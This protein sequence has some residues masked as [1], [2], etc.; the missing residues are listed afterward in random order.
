MKAQMSSSPCTIPAVGKV[1]THP[2]IIELKERMGHEI[3]SRLVRDAIDRMRIKDTA[4]NMDLDAICDKIADEAERLTEPSLRRVINATG[5]VIHTNLGRAPMSEAAANR[6]ARISRGYTNLEIDRVTGRRGNRQ[7][8]LRGLLHLLTGAEDSLVVNNNAAA[9]LLMLRTFALKREVIVS[10]GELIEIGDSFRLPDV[11]REGGAKLVEVG[12]TNR[13]RV[14]DYESAIS[15]KTSMLFKA[16]TSNFKTIGF[17]ESVPIGRLAA[18][19]HERGLI[20]AYDL[21]SGMLRRPKGLPMND[22]PSV[23]DALLAGADIVTFSG[24]KLLGGA[25]AG[26]IAGKA[27]LIARLAKAPL[28]RALRPGRLTLAALEAVALEYLDEGRLMSHNPV[29]RMLARSADELHNAAHKLASKLKQAGIDSDVV[30]SIGQAGGGA[31]AGV[32]LGGWAVRIAQHAKTRRGSKRSAERLHAALIK[33]ETPVLAILREGSLLL[34]VRTI[35]QEELDTAAAAV[36]K[37]STR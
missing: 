17:T 35:E 30:E 12:T 4:V 27:D 26:L 15:E 36:I 14:S 22:E 13:T 3:V 20:A 19:A 24:D 6:L 34:D 31:L 33:G 1:L 5:I 7:S 11:M 28:M 2:R 21:G 29:F 8:H 9:L 16:H 18:L 10:R 25:Q 37:A 32:A 23:E